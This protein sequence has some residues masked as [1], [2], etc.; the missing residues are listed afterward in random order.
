MLF[1]VC[2]QEYHVNVNL[3]KRR[4]SSLIKKSNCWCVSLQ[5]RILQDLHL[6]RNTWF[7]WIAIS[8]LFL[9]RASGGQPQPE[10]LQVPAATPRSDPSTHKLLQVFAC[11]ALNNNYP[12]LDCLVSE[13]LFNG[14]IHSRY[15]MDSVSVEGLPIENKMYQMAVSSNI[16]LNYIGT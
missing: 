16:Q 9:L 13:K 14:F 7:M 15:S 3:S 10:N 1:Q 12:Q 11:I 8:N 5:M 6:P 4:L 2:L